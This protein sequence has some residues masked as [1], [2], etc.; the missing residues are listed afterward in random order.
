MATI[1]DVA[2]LAGV[3][4]CT[5]SRALANKENITPKTM[6]KVLSA[7]R[8][9]DYKPNYS[10]RSLKI[11]STD[12]LGLIVPDIT[13]PYYPKVAKSIEEYAEKK[14]YMILL[15]NSN[16]DLNKEKRLVDTL[17]KRNVDGVIILPCSRHIAVSYTHL[18]LPTI[19]LV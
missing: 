6:E 18:T 15:C 14:G 4:I 12:T 5:V 3:S 13:N 1:K 2:K 11:G 8:E 19:L 16:E 17:K 7:V 9:L 10:A